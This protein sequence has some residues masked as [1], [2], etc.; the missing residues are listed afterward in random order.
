MSFVYDS[1]GGYMKKI[2]K[3]NNDN[4]DIYVSRG[5]VGIYYL[6]LPQSWF[7]NANHIFCQVS[8]MGAVAG[9]SAACFAN[10]YSVGNAIYNGA[11]MYR[12]EVRTADD[13]SL[14]DGGFQFMIYNLASWDD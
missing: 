9:A 7:V 6:W 14:N 1:V 4:D 5:G 10:V 13:A 12:V 2:R 11:V 3:F 8:G